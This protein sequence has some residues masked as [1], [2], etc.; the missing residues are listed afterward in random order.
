MSGIFTEL[1]GI[2]S[3]GVSVDTHGSTIGDQI[4]YTHILVCVL[5]MSMT[6]LVCKDYVRREAE[7][8]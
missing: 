2:V 7:V 6:L 4:A 1:A 5:G 8:C 3:Y